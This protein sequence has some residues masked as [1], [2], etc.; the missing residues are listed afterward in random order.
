MPRR[1]KRLNNTLVNNAD[2]ML[3]LA[4]PTH[5]FMIGCTCPYGPGGRDCVC[6]F[7]R[8]DT[9]GRARAAAKRATKRRKRQEFKNALKGSSYR[10]YREYL[11]YEYED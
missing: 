1:N 4:S 9:P 7:N 11:D 2:D 3:A 5:E 8:G 10:S 6:F